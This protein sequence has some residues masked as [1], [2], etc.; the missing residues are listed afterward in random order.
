MRSLISKRWKIMNIFVKWRTCWKKA[1]SRISPRKN[2]RKW[3]RSL[4]RHSFKLLGWQQL[5]SKEKPKRPRSRNKKNW[6]RK[7]KKKKRKLRYKGKKS[8]RLTIISVK[9]NIKGGK[10]PLSRWKLLRH[11]HINRWRRRNRRL[12]QISWKRWVKKKTGPFL[13]KA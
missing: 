6:T 7:G 4:K 3:K 5:K 11:Q 9:V 8:W 13:L 12:G 2:Y 10:T 1:I